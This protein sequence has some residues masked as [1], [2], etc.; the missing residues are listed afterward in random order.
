MIAV[1]L[2]LEEIGLATAL[3]G[4]ETTLDGTEGEV[5]LDF[6]AVNRID[7][8]ALQALEDFARTARA[9]DI[10]VVIRGINV[11]VYKVL[12]LAKLASQFTFAS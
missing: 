1:S 8:H 3:Q 4:A 12:K 9:K 6:A 5:T 7:S 2:K 10:P 11:A